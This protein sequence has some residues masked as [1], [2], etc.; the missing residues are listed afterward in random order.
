MVTTGGAR[1]PKTRSKRESDRDLEAEAIQK[2][3]A[4]VCDVGMMVASNPEL[5]TAGKTRIVVSMRRRYGKQTWHSHY[6]HR[7]RSTLRRHRY[8]TTKDGIYGV[9]AERRL[10]KFIA[11]P[12][13]DAD[14]Y[15]VEARY[16]GR[17]PV[18]LTGKWFFVDCGDLTRDQAIAIRAQL[19]ELI[20]KKAR[21]RTRS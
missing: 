20:P 1:P 2:L 16:P 21:Y 10:I 15:A 7:I 18:P 13:C 8:V 17:D 5:P 12:I 19:K 9:T 14:C 4:T 6:T 11:G 3:Q